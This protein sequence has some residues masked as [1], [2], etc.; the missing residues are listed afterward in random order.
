MDASAEKIGKREANREALQQR[1][2]DALLAAMA[3]GE[4]ARITHES[5]AEAV[6]VSRRTVYRYYPDRDA[7]MKALWR[8]TT[9][10]F[11]AGVGFPRD[12]EH[13]LHRLDEVFRGYEDNAAAAMVS[14]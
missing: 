12:A 13:V 14:L 9:R 8:R 5:V 10:A 6:G 4:P 7:L 2:E 1:I 3:A 11:G